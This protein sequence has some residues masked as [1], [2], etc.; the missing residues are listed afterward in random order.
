[1]IEN[2]DFKHIVVF[3]I[4]FVELF[5]EKGHTALLQIYKLYK[6]RMDDVTG[7]RK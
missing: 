7:V 4:E 5:M 3:L 2:T 1:M 6:S